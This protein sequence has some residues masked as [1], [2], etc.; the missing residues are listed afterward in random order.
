MKK[1]AGIA[2][3]II[4][5]IGLTDTAEKMMSSTSSI[6]PLA[7]LLNNNTPYFKDMPVLMFSASDVIYWWDRYESSME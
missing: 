7:D 3:Y 5:K 4:Y 1:L 6:Q 2:T